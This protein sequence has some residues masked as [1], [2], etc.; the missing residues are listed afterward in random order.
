MSTNDTTFEIPPRN[1][2]AFA[3]YKAGVEWEAMQ[4]TPIEMRWAAHLNYHPGWGLRNTDR[5]FDWERFDYREAPEL[6]PIDQWRAMSPEE[7]EGKVLELHINDSIWANCSD[8]WLTLSA[9]AVEDYKSRDA[10]TFRI[11]ELTLA[12]RNAEVRARWEAMEETDREGVRRDK[13][14]KLWGWTLDGLPRIVNPLWS[15]MSVSEYRIVPA[16]EPPKPRYVP[17]TRET[18]PVGA[19]VKKKAHSGDR[20]QISAA[21]L[22]K[23]HLTGWG[24][25]NYSGLLEY[26]TMDDGTPCGTLEQPQP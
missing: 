13:S 17:W 20:H 2:K 25:E 19:V 3:E 14:G 5:P 15:W 1:T 23:V 4:G 10:Y 12:E 26:W 21:W 24:R 18:C 16:P 9:D 8:R 22:L 6:H 7:R 11:R